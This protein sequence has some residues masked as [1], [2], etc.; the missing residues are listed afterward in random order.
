MTA[1]LLESGA[2]LCVVQQGLVNPECKKKCMLAGVYSLV[3]W[4][5]PETRKLSYPYICNCE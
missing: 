1:A 5:P 3:S 4:K 2:A